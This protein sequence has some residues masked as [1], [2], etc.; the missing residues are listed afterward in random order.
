MNVG[1]VNLKNI[2]SY[3]KSSL[4]K[5]LTGG[6]VGNSSSNP[7]ETIKS[8]NLKTSASSASAYGAHRHSA[9]AASTNANILI[10]SNHNGG[11]TPHRTQRQSTNLMHRHSNPLSSYTNTNV[12]G[13]SGNQP[14]SKSRLGQ[15]ANSVNE[16]TA[17]AL[18]RIRINS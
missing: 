17:N 4:V 9:S 3:L 16:A 7:S 8:I 12:L 10:D 15:A 1:G 14:S 18:P 5:N 11:S 13:S 6:T 2:G